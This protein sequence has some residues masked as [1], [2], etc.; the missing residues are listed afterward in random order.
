MFV[1]IVNVQA[2]SASIIILISL[3]H[4]TYGECYRVI[5]SFCEQN[6]VLSIASMRTFKKQRRAV[7]SSGTR[8][9]PNFI[10]K[11]LIF[12]VFYYLQSKFEFSKIWVKI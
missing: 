7:K 1:L 9:A 2:F 5:A 4:N 3:D 8:S 12:V 6:Y 10:I 11:G